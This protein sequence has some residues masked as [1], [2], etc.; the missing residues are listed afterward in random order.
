MRYRIAILSV[1]LA[2]SA[3]TTSVWGENVDLKRARHT[4]ATYMSALTGQKANP[5]EARLVYQV[6]NTLQPSVSACYVFNIPGQGFIMVAG[7]DSWDPIIA[8]NEFDTIDMT[9]LSPSTMW[10][11]NGVSSA[12]SQVQNEKIA[13]PA[14]VA[15]AWK[16]IDNELLPR[17]NTKEDIILMDEH[18]NQTGPTDRTP[19]YNKRCPDS[20]GYYCPV[21][22]VATALSQIMHYWRYPV[23]GSSRKWFPW[24]TWTSSGRTTT[25]T[26]IKY[27][28]V[29]YDYDLMPNQLYI[30]SPLEQIDT[31]ALF[32]MHVGTAVNM[33]Y[34]L[35]GSGSNEN[36]VR[37]ALGRYF[38]YKST[39][40]IKYRYNYYG[41]TMISDDDWCNLIANEIDNR[42]PVYYGG[43]D[44]DPQSGA[45]AAHAFVCH[46]YVPQATLTFFY[47][48]WGWGNSGDG[49]YNM[50]NRHGLKPRQFNYDFYYEQEAIIGIEPPDDS[51]RFVGITTP[52]NFQ[53]QL[54]P[55]YPNPAHNSIVI[56]YL[57]NS[58]T[59]AEMLIMDVAGKVV[60]RIKVQPGQH[61]VTLNVSR[62]AKGIYVYRMNGLSRKF[63][64]N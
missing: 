24:P 51:N 26:E 28:T 30:T 6:P 13:A 18:W 21:G 32:C 2:F 55:A 29:I 14:D 39:S 34:N 33:N 9:N 38:K 52:T 50:R 54:M 63:L 7:S 64:V 60:E 42:R 23:Q 57:L 36:E 3:F 10:W 8:Y 20:A 61:E 4:A 1:I 48:N 15:Q 11:I 22:C 43:M 46:G 41:E 19:T 45:D 49:K 44:A 17:M 27:N 16:E 31:T 47:F 5:N 59:N 40:K 56:P 58:N 37:T 12:I 53:T 35:G 62:Y 25:N